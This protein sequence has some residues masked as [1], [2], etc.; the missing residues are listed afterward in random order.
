VLRESFQNGGATL[1]TYKNFDGTVGQYSS[2]FAVYN[3]KTDPD[4]NE[5]IKEKTDDGRTTHW[6]P[7]VQI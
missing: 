5:V 2:R 6:V 1:R 3:Q 4:G 7:S